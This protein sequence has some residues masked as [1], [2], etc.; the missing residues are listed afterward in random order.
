MKVPVLRTDVHPGNDTHRHP[1]M[2]LSPSA[3]VLAVAARL[4]PALAAFFIALFAAA[5]LF[6]VPAHAAWDGTPYDPE[7]TLDPECPPD[8]PQCRVTLPVHTGEGVPAGSIPYT[9]DMDNWDALLIGAE[10][11]VLKVQSGALT[12]ANDNG[13]VA[14]SA[15]DQGITLDAGSNVFSLELDGT[16]LE[17]SA[18]GLRLSSAYAGQPTITTLGTITTGTWQ[19][20]T[21]GAQ[22]GGTGSTAVPGVGQLLIGNGTGYTAANVSGSN[23]ISVTNGA[24]SLGLSFS[25]AGL[26]T[27]MAPGSGDYVAVFDDSTGAAMR[28]TVDDLLSSVTGALTYQGTWN[29]ST[30]TPALSSGSCN[31][32]TEGDYYVVATAGST[33][34]SGITTWN[35]GDWAICDGT[36][37]SRIQTS[38]AIASVFGRTGAVTAQAGD[39]AA[40]QITSSST[41]TIAATN[42][43]DALAELSMEK[44]TVIATGTTGQYWR[45]DKTWQ[46]LDTAAVAEN[47]L[48]LYYTDA[49]AR[50]ALS[51]ASPSFSYST[52]TGVF[53]LTAGYSIPR[54]GDTAGETLAWNGSE[55]VPTTLL[56]VSTSTNTV[57][58]AGSA[59]LGTTTATGLTL[60]TNGL[61]LGSSTPVSTGGRL[62]NQ[63]GTLYWD[64]AAIADGD[65][66]LLSAGLS[67]GDVAYWDGEEWGSSPSLSATADG[68]IV[69]GTASTT[70]LAVSGLARA[71]T[72]AVD[73]VTNT[74]GLVV[75][76]AATT[77]SLA[78]GTLTTTSGLVVTSGATIASSTVG[79]L[80]ATTA[81]LTNA[82]T[83]ALSVAN[84]LT[85]GASV[86]S[87]ILNATA[88][89][90][91]NGTNIN[92]A[93]V[94]SNVGYLNQAQVFTALQTFNGNASTTGLTV[95]AGAYLGTGGGN[96]GIGTTSPS[97]K[98]SIQATVG[99]PA[100]LIGS[101]TGTA[102]AVDANGRLGIGLANPSYPLHVKGDVG[103][104]VAKFETA[105]GGLICSLISA[106]GL[107]TCV[108]DRDLK[109]DIESL[110]TRSTYEKVLAL[111]PVSYR[112][113]TDD[114]STGLKYGFIA[115]EVEALFPEL[116]SVDPET[117]YRTLATG[118]LVPFIVEALQG[119][120]EQIDTLLFRQEGVPTSALDRLA[121]SGALRVEGHVAFGKDTV[122]EAELDAGETSV[123]VAF[124]EPY[125]AAPVV[126]VTPLGEVSGA[127]WIGETTP[128]GFT[129]RV[130]E[131]L[132]R[133]VAFSWHA[134]AKSGTGLSI[135]VPPA[136]PIS[137]PAPSAPDAGSD[138]PPADPII[139]SGPADP[140]EPADADEGDGATTEQ[141]ATDEETGSSEPEGNDNEKAD[142]IDAEPI[143][144][145]E[146]DGSATS[147][148]GS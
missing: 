70:G 52:T 14:Y 135:P 115:Q 63:G 7:E 9:S 145:A 8:E 19:G 108:S 51:S 87:P 13:G 105:S 120:Q 43:Q 142:E 79:T 67:L 137:E 3:H 107:L 46:V 96:V 132:D 76:G 2:Q 126:T 134:F 101:S 16:T 78:V 91:L 71:G 65:S 44:E 60:T 110:D 104:A 141:S 130:A 12:W 45:G 148:E 54:S 118:G 39:Y 136:D 99:V 38:D 113:K 144:S 31:L 93:G 57:A 25:V 35:V 73:G 98:L 47:G 123:T 94:L 139:E 81:R 26:G 82:S 125:D 80:T 100:L 27:V 20:T 114:S 58:V 55:W 10:G 127:Y 146:P 61:A 40:A 22:Y 128:E 68:L 102:I 11:Q 56:T 74:T 143:E 89:L 106:T 121:L 36:A 129:I 24:G 64:G 72:L 62:Y 140:T 83:T 116:V 41:G 77:T 6:A 1:R 15:S 117:G 131:P 42:V 53:A 18:D 90:Q 17:A 133:A 138:V 33:D 66:G 84:G 119:Q 124:A 37:W 30:N 122:G 109:T 28:I 50:S 59:S 48:R 34:L 5:A 86:V 147:I 21:V 97:A 88:G 111:N 29:A 92:T 95:T 85:V 112:W 69:D 75:A 32:S 49:R 23:G 4:A 103:G